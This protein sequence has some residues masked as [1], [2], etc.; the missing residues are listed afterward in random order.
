MRFVLTALGLGCAVILATQCDWESS[1]RSGSPRRS[2]SITVRVLD[3][4]SNTVVGATVEVY[5][6]L[7]RSRHSE[8]TDM[9]GMARIANIPAA[10]QSSGIITG[11][12]KRWVGFDYGIQVTD[13]PGEYE[14]DYK[15]TS[16]R[17]PSQGGSVMV[18]MTPAT[19]LRPGRP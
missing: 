18:V 6:N 11:G 10:Y 12:G 7:L 19:D 2:G 5:C 15:S 1:G 4:D 3:A 16:R 13:C 14:C 8:Q 9:W 17:M